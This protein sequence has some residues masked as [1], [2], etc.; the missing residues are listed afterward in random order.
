MPFLSSLSRSSSRFLSS[1]FPSLSS[2]VSCKFA[3]PSFDLPQPDLQQKQHKQNIVCHACL[4]PGHKSYACPNNSQL[5]ALYQQQ[6]S[7][8]D[9][10]QKNG[11]GGAEGDQ[12]ANN[13]GDN[14]F[15]KL[16][17]KGVM[18]RNYQAF[19]NYDNPDR[20][21]RGAEHITCYKCG[22]LGH[23]ANRCPK[24]VLGFLHQQQRQQQQQQQPQQG[25]QGMDQ[26]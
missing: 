24:G 22:E 6:Q 11:G 25:V 23:F 17:I 14:F 1:P 26:S 7:S 9:S 18:G 5:N 19:R 2:G 10:D 15:A 4:E 20:P 8:N 12:A 21:V 16:N 3:H 13:G